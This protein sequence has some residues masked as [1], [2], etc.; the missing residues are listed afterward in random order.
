LGETTTIAEL[1]GPGDTAIWE[2]LA[3]IESYGCLYQKRD[4]NKIEDRS[5]ITLWLISSKF[6]QNFN[7]PP[8]DYI[9]NLT[10]VGKGVSSGFLAKF[11][12]YLVDLGELPITLAT[13]PLLMVYEDRK[14]REK[15]IIRFVIEHYDEL[16][17]YGNF[18]FTLHIRAL[19]EVLE[20][21][22]LSNLRGLE[23]DVPGIIDL[24][25]LDR[26]VE[27]AGEDKLMEKIGED[28]LIQKIGED[29]LIQKIGKDKLIQKI[30]PEEA[31]E[32]ASLYLT[33]KRIEEILDKKKKED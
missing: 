12:I 13:I 15:E 5:Q 9:D 20:E 26:I 33:R 18:L 7:Q 30:G 21:M 17:K 31:I 11:P 1:K 16:R 6:S 14:E 3:Q 27:T 2:D 24:L 4:E 23:L 29:R 28:R 32:I 22:D 19:E 10:S 25:G 8:G